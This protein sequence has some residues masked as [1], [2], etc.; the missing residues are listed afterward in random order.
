ML[1]WNYLY[2]RWWHIDA[3]ELC[4]FISVTRS[5][6]T[7]LKMM[8]HMLVASKHIGVDVSK[9]LWAIALMNSSL[10]VLGPRIMQVV[11]R[12]QI[13]ST[14]EGFKKQHSSSNLT[15]L[16]LG[17]HF[18]GFRQ[19]N[20]A[21]I[22]GREKTVKPQR[23]AAQECLT[24]KTSQKSFTHKK[25]NFCTARNELVGWR[26]PEYYAS[27]IENSWKYCRVAETFLTVFALKFSAVTYANAVSQ[28]YLL[29]WAL[30]LQEKQLQNQSLL[31][32]GVQIYGQINSDIKMQCWAN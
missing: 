15:K 9:K 19:L 5:F 7:C 4:S 10:S 21:G 28:H 11:F 16:K 30:I 27:L 20:V 3:L 26:E 8:Q 29:D 12:S 1:N 6:P 17:K 22:C 18:F 14:F 13:V 23:S 31:K 2:E 24:T 32:D 25:R